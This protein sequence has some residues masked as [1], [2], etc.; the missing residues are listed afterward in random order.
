MHVHVCMSVHVHGVG[1][2]WV[3]A[4]GHTSMGVSVHVC[5]LHEYTRV[6]ACMQV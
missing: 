1:W 5:D 4:R 6:C 2:P 3:C